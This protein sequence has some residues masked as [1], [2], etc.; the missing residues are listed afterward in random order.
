MVLDRIQ[1]CYS[2]Q[3]YH[4][5]HINEREYVWA[6]QRSTSKIKKPRKLKLSIHT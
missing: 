6:S 2:K 5:Y 1:R 4:N 3:N